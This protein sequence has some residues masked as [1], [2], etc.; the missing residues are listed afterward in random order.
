MKTKI[1]LASLLL[2]FMAVAG[3]KY[4]ESDL[5]VSDVNVVKNQQTV[6]VSMHMD[7]TKFPLSSNQELVV[8][9]MI[10]NASQSVQLPSVIFA[11][12]NR[13]YS[14]KRNADEYPDVP[15]MRNGS[16][17]IFDYNASTAYQP[18]MNQSNL[19]I[20]YQIRG[21]CGSDQADFAFDTKQLQFTPPQYTADFLYIPP[22]AERVK[23]RQETG[24][25][26]I[27]FVVNKTA[28]LPDYH[29]NKSELAKITNTINSVKDDPDITLKSMEIKG[30]ASP[31]GGYE[32]NV[33]LAKGRTEALEQY[34]QKLYSFP[35][36]FIKTSSDPAN[37]QGLVAWLDTNSIDNKGAILDIINSNLEPQPKNSKIKSSYP[38]QYAWLLEHVYPSLRKSDYK[39]DYTVKSYTDVQEIINVMQT[40]P[41]KL[42]LSE[43]YLAA[44]SMKPGSKEFNNV[45]DTAVK[46]YPEDQ[47]ANLN[48]ANSA[49]QRG[50]LVSAATY[51]AKAGNSQ[52]ATY[53]RG[54]LAA[55]N[56]DYKTAASIFSQ[57]R[58]LQQAQNALNQIEA[59]S[60]FTGN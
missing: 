23:T 2:P 10:K 20:N 60:A 57:L 41:N 32:N 49:M 55:L 52:E 9:P 56:K 51:L 42:S 29:N 38:K 28:I 35:A 7:Y 8:T 17:A 16:K 53:A 50:D 33:R 26:Y 48:A 59:I 34:V 37:F 54:V 3:V 31:E 44:Q 40:A 46:M 13:Y 36:G 47:V 39:I 27:D 24:T 14:H 43:F 15:V 4:S 12:K 19:I 1:F 21:C 22:V 6:N 45:F 5:N 30:Y 11:G 58:N 25:A 18:W